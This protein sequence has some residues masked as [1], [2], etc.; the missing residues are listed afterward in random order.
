[1]RGE[2]PLY[3]LGGKKWEVEAVFAGCWNKNLGVNEWINREIVK[4][5]L[6]D[7]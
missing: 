4:R 1:M 7:K 3:G 2:A 6:T 5:N